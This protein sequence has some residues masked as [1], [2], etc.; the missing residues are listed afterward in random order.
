MP[1]VTQAGAHGGAA[2]AAVEE[3]KA[4]ILLVDD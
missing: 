3:P 2:A 1:D 4:K